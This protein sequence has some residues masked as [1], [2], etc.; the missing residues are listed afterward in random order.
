M[1]IE[2]Q[3][4]LF[5]A[6]ILGEIYRLQ[7]HSG[8]PC[9]AEDAQI[10][11]LLKGFEDVVD[12]ELNRVGFISKAQLSHVIDVLNPIDRDPQKASAFNGFYAIEDELL[13]GGIDRS[14]AIRILTYLNANDQFSALIAKMNS[15]NSP[16][17]CKTFE[18]NEWE[19]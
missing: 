7:R 3:N 2:T 5:L 6:K 17:E 14:A 16:V 4:K 15:S 9:P 18:L 12:E 8:L 13:K 10:Y 11:G 1:E 19:S